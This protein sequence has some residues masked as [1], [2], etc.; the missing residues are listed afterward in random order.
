MTLDH[1]NFQFRLA[2]QAVL[3]RGH[4]HEIASFER[5]LEQGIHS[6]ERMKHWWISAKSNLSVQNPSGNAIYARGLSDL[7]L[8]NSHL[9]YVDVPETLQ[10]DYTR[11]L[12]LRARTFQMVAVSSI[13]LT[14]KIRLRRNRESLWTKDA[15]RLMSLDLLA[16]DGSRV[17]SLVESSHIMPESTKQ[18]LSNFVER[19]LPAAVIAARNA[20][21]AD[22]AHQDAIQRRTTYDTVEASTDDFFSEQIACFLLK[23]LREHI[24]ARLS[25]T[26]TAERVRATTSA[27]EVLARAGMP[28]FVEEV[29]GLVE[30]LDK[31]RSVDL[32]AH[33]KWYDQI[34]AEAA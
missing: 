9:D 14:T 13:L 15:E 28:E 27:A 3:E 25:A 22:R 33:E 8:R 5:D 34:A 7:L 4:E 23:S 19:V 20:D 26:G 11:L 31:M 29:N 17:V 18:G 1:I 12:R 21:A 2:S 16:N 10:L 30:T 6:L 24:F 32:K